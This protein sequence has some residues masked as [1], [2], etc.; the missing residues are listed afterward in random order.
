MN[1]AQ[2]WLLK[3]KWSG[4]KTEGFFADCARLEAGEP[5]AYVIGNIPFLNTLISLGSHPLIPRPE[6]EYWVGNAIG[7]LPKNK[8]L[9]ILDLCAGSGAIGVAAGK[10]L[11]MA[12]VDFA[13]IDL[14]HHGTIVGN[15]CDNGLDYTLTRVFGG[16]LFSDIPRGTQYDAILSNPPYIDPV[17]D[18]AEESVKK[19]EPKNALY[20]GVGGI[21]LI[22]RIMNDARAYLTPTGTLWM[23]HE[24]EQTA[25]ITRLGAALGFTV[26]TQHDQFGTLRFSIFTH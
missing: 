1:K 10:A 20:G 22:I 2:E 23:E 15:I 13:E 9:R 18:R 25:Y 6:T 16:D 4:E 7:S 5:L 8:P 3:E 19:Y 26:T 21:E 14:C 12:Q 24:P 11:P 17:L